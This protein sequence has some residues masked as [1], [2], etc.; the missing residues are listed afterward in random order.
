MSGVPSYVQVAPD[1]TGKYI[2]NEAEDMPQTDGTLKTTQIQV[3]TLG[4]TD[5]QRFERMERL[6]RL[7]LGAMIMMLELM[8]SNKGAPTLRDIAGFA[9]DMFKDEY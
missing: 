2:R 9:E 3:V 6:M 4:E 1:S 5:R 7:Q 8:R